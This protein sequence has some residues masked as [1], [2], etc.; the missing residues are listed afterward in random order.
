MA[1]TLAG[2]KWGIHI[3]Y[4]QNIQV[5]LNFKIYEIYILFDEV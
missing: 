4:H 2:L 1:Q 3:L 5:Y